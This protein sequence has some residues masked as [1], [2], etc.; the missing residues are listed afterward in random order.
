MLK[1]VASRLF[2]ILFCMTVVCLYSKQAD[3]ASQLNVTANSVNKT[4][5]VQVTDA[6]LNGKEASVVCYSPKW[7]G[8]YSDWNA[9]KQYIVYMTQVKINTASNFSFAIN[10]NV[11]AGDYSVVIGT[12]AGRI[13][14]KVNFSATQN[15][16]VVTL[17]APTK[18]KAVQ[19]AAK[20][21]KVTWQAV[22]G[23]TSYNVYRSTKKDSGYALVGTSAKTS[24]T[25]KKVKAGKTYYYKVTAG[26]SGLSECAK[27]T[28]MKAPKVTAKSSKG[29][30]VLS[31]KKDNSADGYKVYMSNKKKGKYKVKATLKGK[32]KIKSTI[33]KLKKGK[34]YYFKVRAYS[35]S[36]KKNVL[37]QFSS[38]KKIKVK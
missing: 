27:V 3:A 36:G 1:K 11:E 28:L 14:N 35:K 33:K 31:W 20:Q 12:D 24:Y 18:V 2:A 26:N 37:G 23:A 13:V 10:G 22:N 19:Q 6:S 9:N 4:I 32:K 5:T 21:V 38:V 34:T 25:D 15:T 7:N 29:K 17:T 30:V 8:V 16:P